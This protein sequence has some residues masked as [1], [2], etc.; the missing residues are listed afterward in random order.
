MASPQVHVP[1]SKLGEYMDFIRD[2]R[3]NLEIFLSAKDLISA[4]LDEFQALLKRLSYGPSI[5]IHAPFMDL[6]PAAVDPGVKEI[7]QERFNQAFDAATILRPKA[8]VFHS[9]YDKWKYGQRVDIWLERSARFWPY[10]IE[11]AEDLETRI[12]VENIFEDSPES[13]ALL[14]GRLGSEN[15]GI[16]FDTGHMNIFSKTPLS[17][18][19]DELGEY[20]VELHLHD[21]H[22]DEDSHLPI[23]KGI[24]DFDTLFNALK[25]RDV[26][27]TIEATTPEDVLESIEKLKL[28]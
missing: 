25:D 24:F 1:Y 11:R 10:Y 8:I 27:R 28:Y 15:F 21:N 18:W 4:S 20:I 16:C 6:S 12:A 5:T 17:E 9:G 2:Y 19:L 3:L 22:G 14:M 23:G 26:I 7:T 13:L